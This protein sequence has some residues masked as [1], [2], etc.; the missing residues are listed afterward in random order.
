RWIESV[1]LVV[2]LCAVYSFICLA[3]WYPVKS[4]PLDATPMV[5][6]T[7]PPVLAATILSLLWIQLAKGLAYL[8]SRSSSFPDLSQRVSSE[9][10]SLFGAGFLLYLLAVAS[11]YVIFSLEAS[12]EAQGRAMQSSILTRDAELKALKAQVNPHFLFNSLNS[13]SALTSI[14]PE[15]AREM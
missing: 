2:P 12:R 5:R 6:L 3:A 14:D 10:P 1:L 8:L 4:A 15:R 7:L 13:V 11:H 9:L